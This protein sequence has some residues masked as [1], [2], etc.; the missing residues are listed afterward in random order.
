MTA[1]SSPL[2]SVLKASQTGFPDEL[3]GD[4]RLLYTVIRLKQPFWY[5]PVLKSLLKAEEKFIYD[6]FDS[7]EDTFL[8]VQA[9]EWGASAVY[10]RHIGEEAL[11]E[12]YVCYAPDCILQL[13]LSWEPTAEQIAIIRQ[14]LGL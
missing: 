11:P 13:D 8:L 1:Q 9:P 2:A 6:P 5:E 10:Q 3:G 7:R 14:K 12:F 4:E